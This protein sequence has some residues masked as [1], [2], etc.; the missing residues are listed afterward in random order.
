MTMLVSAINRALLTCKH[1]AMYR[2]V[3]TCRL[4]VWCRQIHQNLYLSVIRTCH[5]IIQYMYLVRDME[6]E[7]APGLH[8]ETNSRHQGIKDTGSKGREQEFIIK[9]PGNNETGKMSRD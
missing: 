6:Y 4:A 3:H 2:P 9:G 5:H 7:Q 8:Q 1:E